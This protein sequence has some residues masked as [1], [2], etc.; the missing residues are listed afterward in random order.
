MLRRFSESRV[1]PAPA[2]AVRSGEDFSTGHQGLEESVAPS[3]TR[4]AFTLSRQASVLANRRWCSPAPASRCGRGRLPP[5]DICRGRGVMDRLVAAVGVGEG[6]ELRH[7]LSGGFLAEF[8][9]VDLFGHQAIPY[10]FNQGSAGAPLN[11]VEPMPN[12]KPSTFP[13]I[14]AAPLY[15]PRWYR[16]SARPGRCAPAGPSERSSGH[17]AC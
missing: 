5:P 14:S 15:P 16:S 13:S 12:R 11:V 2:R 6:V 4:T 9:Q 7:L 8:R 10:I 17:S 3:A 1:L